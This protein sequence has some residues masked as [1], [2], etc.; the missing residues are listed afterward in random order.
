MAA[1]RS[2]AN[3]R[4]LSDTRDAQQCQIVAPDAEPQCNGVDAI[5]RD[6]D[7]LGNVPDEAFHLDAI[8]FIESRSACANSQFSVSKFPVSERAQ[9]NRSC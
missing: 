1:Y 7:L 8:A 6:G 2:K 4:K 5:S 9:S 3:S